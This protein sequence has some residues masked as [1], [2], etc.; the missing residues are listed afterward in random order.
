MKKA[1]AGADHPATVRCAIYTRKSTEEGLEQAFNSLDAQREAAE[2]Y[3][4]SQANEGWVCLAERYDDGGFSGGNMDRPALQ[5]LLADI[6]AGKVDCVVLYKIDRL[7]RSLLDFARLME[8]FDRRQVCFVS[9][10]QQ[11]NSATSMGRLLLNVL[12]SFA[13]FE[14]EMIAERTRDK[15]AA[16]RRKG[17]WSGGRPVLGYDIDRRGVRLVVNEPEAERVRAI[18]D[19]YSKHQALLPVIEELERRGWRT[20]QWATRK[21]KQLGGQPFI[22]TSLHNL[23]TNVLYIGKVRYKTEVH[24]GEHPGIVD[25]TVWHQVQDLLRNKRVAKGAA[26]RHASDALL[27]GLLHCAACGFAM[28]P[29]Y[30]CRNGSKRY[31]YYVCSG[32]LK[33]GRK[34]CPTRMVPAGEFERFVLEQ[35][36]RTGPPEAAVALASDS[37]WDGRASAEQSDIIHRLVERI[38]YD[39][40]QGKIAIT[41]AAPETSATEN[42]I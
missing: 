35:I 13:Q 42:S 33:R 12:L 6:E 38:G 17:K 15:I 36:C 2:A 20:K 40:R 14:R 5:R 41:F 32:V 30:S 18:F 29:T 24:P 34:S 23:L 27:K 10:T 26:P 7:S 9:V 21:G 28:T 25:E 22:K 37:A 39:D 16:T 11:V 3:I 19:L 4:K 1:K 31:R 8:I